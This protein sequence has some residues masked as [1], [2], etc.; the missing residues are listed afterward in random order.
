MLRPRL[1][2]SPFLQRG[3]LPEASLELLPTANK[4]P[5]SSVPEAPLPHETP[6]SYYLTAGF[7]IVCLPVVLWVLSN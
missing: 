2:S 3:F 1:V 4:P 5:A 7:V 6:L